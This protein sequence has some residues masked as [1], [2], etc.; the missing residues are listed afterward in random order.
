MNLLFTCISQGHENS[1]CNFGLFLNAHPA[2]N[3]FIQKTE[4]LMGI[5]CGGYAGIC[6]IADGIAFTF[7]KYHDAT[8]IHIAFHIETSCFYTFLY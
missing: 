4:R 6:D 3:L 1:N 8:A 2:H 7:I 5:I